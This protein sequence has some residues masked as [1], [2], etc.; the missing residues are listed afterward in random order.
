MSSAKLAAA[1][2]LIALVMAGC[3]SS[4]KPEAGSVHTS[5][6]GHAGR[7]VIDDPRTKHLMCLKQHGLV[8]HRVGQTGIQVGKLP[9]GPS[10]A[11]AQTPGAAQALQI[12]GTVENAEVIGSALLYPRQAPDKLLKVVEACMA[13]GVTG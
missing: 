4:S 5:A 13:Q 3:G 6:G 2:A 7:G 8:A 1:C 10:I 9:T 11:F 12:N